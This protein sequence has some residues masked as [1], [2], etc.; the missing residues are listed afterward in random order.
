MGETNETQPAFEKA[1]YGALL[2]QKRIEMGYRKAEDFVADLEAIGFKISRAALYRIE[3]G[4]Q[5]PT[6][7]F[8]IASSILLFGETICSD[9]LNPC[10]PQEWADPLSSDAIMRIIGRNGVLASRKTRR[11]ASMAERAARYDEIM[12]SLSS[13][14]FD[15][16]ANSRCDDEHMFITVAYGAG[17]AQKKDGPPQR[18]VRRRKERSRGGWDRPMRSYPRCRISSQGRCNDARHFP[19]RRYDAQPRRDLRDHHDPDEQAEAEQGRIAVASDHSL[20]TF[21][22]LSMQSRA[23]PRSLIA[24]PL[25][26]HRHRYLKASVHHLASIGETPSALA[27]IERIASSHVMLPSPM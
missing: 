9:L 2:R 10:I 26:G 15:V 16:F 18:P 21:N 24:C 1:M 14:D 25:C 5:E 23:F 8:L 12:S 13:F 19:A 3:R 11:N 4:E 7:S 22:S 27:V 6:A 20:T 17:G